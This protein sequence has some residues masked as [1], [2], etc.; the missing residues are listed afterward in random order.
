MEKLTFSTT[1]LLMTMIAC[2]TL[3]QGIVQAQTQVTIDFDELS[4][5]TNNPTDP[6]GR[7]RDAHGFTSNLDDSLWETEGLTF[8]PLRP[9]DPAN[10]D[11]ERRRRGWSYSNYNDPTTNS[12]TN[13]WAAI[14]GTD[15]SGSGNYVIGNSFDANA[16]LFD[17]P[18]F[19]TV[20]SVQ[21]TNA[22]YTARD[23]E[24]GSPF[25]GP[26]GGATGNDPDVFSVFFTGFSGLGGTGIETGSVEF[27][28]ANYRFA[29][30]SLDYIVDQWTALDLTAINGT[31]AA[32]SIGISF[33]GTKA[34]EEGITNPT[35][36][37]IDNLVLNVA[38]IPEPSSTFA[39]LV[40]GGLLAIRRRRK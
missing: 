18:E 35:Y 9:F 5:Y 24:L 26:F 29:D 30:N 16:A 31:D 10:P 14:T 39:I 12:F 1:A 37:A 22:T 15:F 8:N 2:C 25:G 32:R 21:V 19:M 38:A 20:D 6:N 4:D 17:L 3:S 11:A 36:V 7:Y 23:I 34:N 27:I 13:Q 33:N 28:L 40:A